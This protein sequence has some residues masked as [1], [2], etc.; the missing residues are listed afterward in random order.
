MALAHRRYTAWAARALDNAG[1]EHR[2]YVIGEPGKAY[3]MFYAV[4][5]DGLADIRL[6]ALAPEKKAGFAGSSLY[7]GAVKLLHEAGA[8]QAVSRP[9]LTNTPVINIYA[10]LGFQLRHPEMVCHWH[11]PKAPHLV[12]TRAMWEE[13]ARHDA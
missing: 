8:Q 9:Q 5:R 7:A 2:V 6:G 1:A 4:L 12:D 11:A 3:G 13:D 10:S